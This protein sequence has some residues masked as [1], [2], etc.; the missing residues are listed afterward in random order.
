MKFKLELNGRTFEVST[1]TDKNATSNYDTQ[2]NV[3]EKNTI[4]A[5][6]TIKKSTPK[7]EVEL[8]AKKCV[9]MYL[10]TNWF[11]L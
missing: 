11:A 1:R 2:L 4:V 6:C 9:Q 7:S 5:G 8:A 10:T 3:S